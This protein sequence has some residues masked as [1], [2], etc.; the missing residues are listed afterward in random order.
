MEKNDRDPFSDDRDT[1]QNAVPFARG[2]IFTVIVARTIAVYLHC[3]ALRRV[4]GSWRL[5]VINDVWSCGLPVSTMRVVMFSPLLTSLLLLLS[6]LWLIS[7]LFSVADPGS[8]AFWPLDPWSRIPNPYF[9]ELSD[10]FF[11]KKFRNSL[12]NWPKY[13]SSAFQK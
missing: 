2:S 10:N 4:F 12:E 11:G 13:F 5:P 3:H 9:W 8:G 7:L 6:Q 1:I